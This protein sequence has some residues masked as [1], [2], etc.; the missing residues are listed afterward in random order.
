VLQ[1]GKFNM[2]TNIESFV[3]T[4]ETEGVDAGRKAAQKIEAD[5]KSHAEK[6]ISEAKAKAEQII[7]QANADAE[8]IKVR[9]ISSLELAARDTILM[10]REKLSLQFQNLLQLNVEK[11]L[12]EEETVANILRQVIPA[13]AKADAAGKQAAEINISGSLKTR[14]LEAVLHELKESLSGKNTD[15]DVKNNLAKAGFEFK[16]KGST[17]EVSTESVTAMLVEMIDP[18]L[19]QFLASASEKVK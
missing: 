19:Q 13:Y 10:L 16:I 2:P 8:K 12:R 11:T 17:I 6:I 3:K 1:K 18:D 4:L 14:L 5:A 15:I 9:M 7:N